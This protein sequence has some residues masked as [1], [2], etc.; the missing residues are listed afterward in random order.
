MEVA[1][2]GTDISGSLPIRT[3][4]TYFENYHGHLKTKKEKKAKTTS[5]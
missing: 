3:G 1:K 4:M 2:Q 5:R